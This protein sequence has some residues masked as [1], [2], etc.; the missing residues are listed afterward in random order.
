MFEWED[1]F[2]L[3]EE[4]QR[5]TAMQRK[6]SAVMEEEKVFERFS[7][8]YWW[9]KVRDTV[10]H[11]AEVRPW[12]VNASMDAMFLDGHGSK[13]VSHDDAKASLDAPSLRF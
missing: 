11:F 7:V 1:L 13:R 4:P 12:A 8:M 9:T 3:T 6:L 10:R 5:W 2:E